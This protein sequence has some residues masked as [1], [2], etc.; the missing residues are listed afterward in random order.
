M[1][2]ITSIQVDHSGWVS[3]TIKDK[4]GVALTV[5]TLALTIYDKATGETINARNASDLT[6]IASYAPAGVIGFRL[7]R[8]DQALADA[9]KTS[10]EHVL[11][12]DFTW[13]ATADKSFGQVIYTVT[14]APTL[15]T[16]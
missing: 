12:L 10:E 14:A 9:T 8:A 15:V 11:R 13:N 3:G 4:D 16:P 1:A 6:P 2:A 7:T 5:T